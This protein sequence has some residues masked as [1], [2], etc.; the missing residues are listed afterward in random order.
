MKDYG[1]AHVVCYLR[2][3]EHTLDEKE[4]RFAKTF[5]PQV[6]VFMTRMRFYQQ[7]GFPLEVA[8]DFTFN[9]WREACDRVLTTVTDLRRR[10]TP[11]P[12]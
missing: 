5:A 7:R 1:T 9:E 6:D 8:F 11:Q 12:Y 3:I 4:T 2:Q 10:Q